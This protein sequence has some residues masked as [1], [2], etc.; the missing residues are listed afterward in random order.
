MIFVA[1][2]ARDASSRRQSPRG[3]V[4]TRRD[5][6]SMT[7]PRRSQPSRDQNGRGRARWSG[8]DEHPSPTKSVA[9]TRRRSGDFPRPV[10]SPRRR[11]WEMSRHA[12]ILPRRSS[13]R[14]PGFIARTGGSLN[15]RQA[16]TERCRHH[17]RRREDPANEGPADLV[18][19][20]TP[21]KSSRWRRPG[22]VR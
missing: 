1:E 21:P 19:P 12:A 18:R 9:E 7:R 20:H 16:P 4:P 13:S 2:R 3:R 6:A 11:G 8:V 10:R 15:P 22:R 17:D 5:A 14:R